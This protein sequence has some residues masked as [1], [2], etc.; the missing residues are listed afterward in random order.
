MEN[1][2]AIFI[3]T[4]NKPEKMDVQIMIKMFYFPLYFLVNTKVEWA[5]MLYQTL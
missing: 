3:K 5:T 4:T 2:L 1:L